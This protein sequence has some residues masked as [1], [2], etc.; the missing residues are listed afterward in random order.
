MKYGKFQTTILHLRKIYKL[1]ARDPWKR[2]SHMRGKTVYIYPR[3]WE[4]CCGLICKETLEYIDW[5]D[6]T[7]KDSIQFKYAFKKANKIVI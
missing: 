7:G 3:Y 2:L 4:E 6:F 1:C 5:K